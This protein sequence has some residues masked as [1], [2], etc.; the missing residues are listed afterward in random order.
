MDGDS[1]TD[2][3]RKSSNNWSS[4]SEKKDDDNIEVSHVFNDEE[5]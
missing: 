2:Y 5:E 3:S 1:G 4:A